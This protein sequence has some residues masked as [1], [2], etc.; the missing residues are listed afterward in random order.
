LGRVTGKIPEDPGRSG[1]IPEDPGRSGKIRA[2]RASKPGLYLRLNQLR[3]LFDTLHRFV[4]LGR[5]MAKKRG[6]GPPFYLIVVII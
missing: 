6:F 2:S 4:C 1:K 5:Y 3:C